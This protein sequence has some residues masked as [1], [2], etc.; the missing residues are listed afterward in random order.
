M[1]ILQTPVTLA[2]LV[3]NVLIS[4]L[5]FQNEA[6]LKRNLFI[7]GPILRQRQ[8][9]RLIS[10]GFLHANLFH[11]FVNMYVLYEFGSILEAGIGSAHFATLY[12]LSLLGGSLWSLMENRR[13]LIYSAL[14]AS[15][16]TSGIVMAF[17]LAA[18]TN[19]LGLFFAIPMPAWLL[20]VLFFGVSTWLA[21]RPNKIIGHD[22][23]LGGM[24]FGGAYIL[25]LAPQIWPVF[26][27]AIERALGFG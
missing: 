1:L 21:R 25:V 22:A 8:Y 26:I 13:D 6:F 19:T 18:P 9:H 16:A 12:G 3:A 4:V 10:S 24:L 15:G 5:A 11:L 20:A 27:A 14:G 17:C 23:H 7:V 2:L